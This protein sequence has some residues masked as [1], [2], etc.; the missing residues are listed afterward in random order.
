MYTAMTERSPVH[1]GTG[2]LYQAIPA[3]GADGRN[4]MKLIPVRMV[5]RHFDKSQISQLKTDT[6]PPKALA[7]DITSPPVGMGKKAALSPSATEQIFRK[8]VSLVN[9]LPYQVGSDLGNSLNNHP[10]HQIQQCVNL[11]PIVPPRQLPVTGQCLLILPKTQVRIVPASELPAGIKKPTFTPSANSSPSS[12]L[13]SVTFLSPI[14]ITP[15]SVSGRDAFKLLCNIT[16]TTLCGPPS[17]GSKPHLNF[18]P[19]VPQRH[20]S[21]I[22]WSVEEKDN[23]MAPTLDPINSSVTSETLQVAAERENAGKHCEVSTK[24]V[25]GLSRGKSGEEQENTKQPQQQQS[26]HL[27][28]IGPLMATPVPKSGKSGRPPSDLQVTMKSPALPRGQG[29]QIPPKVQVRTVSESGLPPGIKKPTFTPS[30]NSSPSSGLP[31]VVYTSPITSVNRGVTPQRDS[32]LDT[33]KLLHKTSNKTSWGPPSK[34]SKPHLK[35]IPNVPQRPNF[36]IKWSVEEDDDNSTAP[37][38]DPIDSFVTSEILRV[39]AERENTVKHCDVSTNTV[40]GSSQGK[41]GQGQEN[42]LVMCNGKLFFSAK[43]SSRQYK[44]GK[45]DTLIAAKQIVASTQQSLASVAPQKKQG[46]EILNPNESIQVIDLCDDDAPNDWSQRAA[47]VHMSAVTLANEDNVIFVSYT[48]P[49]SESQ[50]VRLITQMA[51]GTDQGATSSSNNVTVQKRPDGTSGALGRIELGQSMSVNPVINHTHVGVSAGMNMDD[52]DDC[53]IINSQ[54]STSAQ[55]LESMEVDPSSNGIC[56][57]IN[58]DTHNVE[59]SMTSRTSSPEPESCQRADDLL[60]RI[61]GITADVKICLQRIEEASVGSLESE[62]IRSVEEHQETTSRF[63][64]GEPFLQHLYS[65]Q[66]TESCN[67]L[68]NG[69]RVEVLTQQE[70]SEDSSTPSPHSDVGPLECSHFKV[71]TNTSPKGTCGDVETEPMT[72]YGEPI[73]EDFLSADEN[74]FPDS[75][76]TAGRSQT[77]ADLNANTG[78]LGR[79]RKRPTCPCCIAGTQDPA[80]RSSAKSDEPEKGAWTTERTIKKGGRAKASSKDV[81]TSGSISCLMAKNK[82]SCKTSEDPAV[83]G[84]STLSMDSDELE[85]HEQITRLKELLQ[86]KEA[87]LELM[88]NGSISNS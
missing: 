18:I 81:K 35:L 62:C 75:R 24:S 73:E 80:A 30:A 25:T 51:R 7:V 44:T 49:R 79:K 5:N 23:S 9:A 48:P 47:S 76:D 16:N 13:P 32:A 41:I 40:S 58:K 10:L 37:T 59:S 87:A 21:P 67:A 1:S 66:E 82:H 46:L 74:D 14:T 61:F 17:N 2:V 29:L 20:N 84:L 55:Q 34:G 68:T 27:R 53:L 71:N 42:P 22:K 11:L 31:S 50:D 26:V 63:E 6:T 56:F 8:Q 54:Q 38:L 69:N 36:P 28:A 4:I 39:A 45:S 72:G 19:N 43:N 88:K 12:G 57:E 65:Q 83:D 85:L 15:Q 33:L 52:D 77:C 64:D 86:E 60:R 3:V 70:L 78:R